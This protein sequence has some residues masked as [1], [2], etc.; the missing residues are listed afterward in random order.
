MLFVSLI[1]LVLLPG[2][3]PEIIHI[4]TIMDAVVMLIAFGHYA[5]TYYKK[6]PMIQAIEDHED[7]KM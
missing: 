5:L 4:I 6:T 1:L 3:K 7:R 2:L